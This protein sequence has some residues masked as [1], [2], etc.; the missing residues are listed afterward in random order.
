[1]LIDNID[2]ANSLASIRRHIICAVREMALDAPIVNIKIAER[3]YYVDRDDELMDD[4]RN[5]LQGKLIENEDDLAAI[6]VRLEDD[7]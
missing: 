6:G 7:Q 3:Y 5:W 4:I 2:K 1:M